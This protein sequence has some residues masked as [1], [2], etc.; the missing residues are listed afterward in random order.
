MYT[1]SL[2]NMNLNCVVLFI[3]RFF[4]QWQ[5]LHYYT[6]TSCL[7]LL[8]WNDE[9]GGIARSYRQL[10]SSPLR[11][12]FMQLLALKG[13]CQVAQWLRIQLPMQETQVLF[14]GWEDPL[15]KEMSIYSSIL[16]TPVF[17][18]N[19]MD[20]EAWKTAIHGVTRVGH[21][22]VTKQQLPHKLLTTTDQSSTLIVLPFPKCHVSTMTQ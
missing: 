19:P 14:L 8:T 12:S 13:T 22:L 2:N 1:W 20:K 21:G 10:F 5:I 17:L 6:I 18:E 16:A 7:N 15:E 11:P 4:F 9:H 3:G